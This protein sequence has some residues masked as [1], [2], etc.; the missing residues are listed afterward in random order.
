MSQVSQTRVMLRASALVIFPSV[1]ESAKWRLSQDFKISS[2]KNDDQQWYKW[3]ATFSVGVKGCEQIWPDVV[4]RFEEIGQLGVFTFQPFNCSCYAHHW[5]KGGHPLT[6][7][8]PPQKV[9]LPYIPSYTFISR[10]E[11]VF[12]FP[13]IRKPWQATGKL[14]VEIRKWNT[15]WSSI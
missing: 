14:R 7:E 4:P 9:F 8:I 2:D 12:L 1:S 3:T 13:L 11:N 15:Y 6:G 5:C 10:L